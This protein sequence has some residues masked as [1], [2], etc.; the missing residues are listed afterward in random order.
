MDCGAASLAMIASFYGKD[1]PLATLRE[2]TYISK[3]GVSLLGISDAAENIGFKTLCGRFTFEQLHKQA[4]LPCILHWNQEHFIVLAKITKQ[5]VHVIDPARGK[6]KFS[7]DEF[8][9]NWI[10]TRTNSE[11]KGVA[12]LLE[13]TPHFYSN[14]PDE[15]KIRGLS[16]LMRYIYSYRKFF[17][18]L[19]LG[20]LIGSVVQ[21]AFPFLTQAIVDIGIQNQDIGFIY[22]ILLAQ[23]AL[24]AGRLSVELIRRWILLHISTRIN[25]SLLSDF[26]IKL[27]R[28]P[29]GWFDAKLVGDITQRISD[30]SR[31][32]K[33]MT[34]QSLS[35]LFSLMTFFIFGGVL[36]YY[37]VKIFLIFLIGS[38][39]YIGW[40][41]IFLKKRKVLDYKFFSQ[42]ADA[43]SKT[44]QLI[45][46]MQEIK[47]QNCEKIKRWE[48]EDVQANLF[49]TNIK[50]LALEQYQEVGNFL[51]GEGKN[52]LITIIAATAV[53]QGQMTLGMM[54]AV[55]Y[56]IGQLNSPIEKS[57]QFI[58]KW[59]DMKLSLERIN[60]VHEQENETEGRDIIPKIKN[61]DIKITNLHFS[62]DGSPHNYALKNINIVVPSGKT[63]AIV[64]V[65][66]SGKTTLIKQLLLYYKPTSGSLNI[67]NQ[68]LNKVDP[69]WWRKHCGSVMQDGYIFS[70]SIAGN[71]AV[72]EETPNPEKLAMAVDVANLKDTI[73]RMPLK[74]NTKIGLEGNGL[75]KGQLQRIL[76]AR[77]VYKNPEIIFF[78]EATN[79]LDA[80]NERIIVKNLEKHFRGKTMVVVAH[81]LSTVKNADK[82]I[83]MDNGMVVEEGNHQ[84]LTKERGKYYELVKNQLELG[85]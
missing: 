43:E 72:S 8:Y 28:L 5:S 62:Y 79:A 11:D 65:S 48:W 15:K 70:D 69:V 47:L 40:I 63:T 53:I 52:I 31:V 27:M 34:V 74:Y 50:A 56:I 35:T 13:P 60:E 38:I 82:I 57:V 84:K 81:R 71:I 78:D 32:E 23:L 26:F 73:D 2:K 16:F 3:E 24:F 76:I 64:G 7:P 75:S 49:K 4:P 41:T 37:S 33:F 14:K 10:S 12:L 46:G 51:I 44:Y 21:L 67:G 61:K 54:L 36:L 29:M 80:N 85:S 1:Y 18:Q 39:T 25:L 42:R 58:H 17:I 20:L 45:S 77:A 68:N 55:Q 9:N 59:Q 6:L 19:V 66:G 30:H 22:L 83:V